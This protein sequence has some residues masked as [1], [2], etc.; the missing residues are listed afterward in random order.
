MSTAAPSS[1][2][3]TT[4]ATG[5][6]RLSARERARQYGVTPRAL[7]LGTALTVVCD[8]WIHYAEL[9]MGGERGHT[10][11]AGTSTPVGPICLLFVVAA[12][13]LLAGRLLPGLA[14]ASAEILVVYAMIT[15]SAVLS[16]SGQLHFIIPTVV[17]AWHYAND[18]N[19]WASMFHRFVPDVPALA[20]KDSEALDG[21]YKGQASVNWPLWIPQMAT[22]IAFMLA[23]AFATL[24]LVSILRRQW[25]DRERLSFPTVQ[26]PA[27]LMEEQTPLFRK[28]LFWIGA[29]IPFA[30]SVMNTLALNDP[31][32][33]LVS[34]R[35]DT[36]LASFMTAAPWNAMGRTPLSFYPFV[37][38]IAY[39]IPLDVT[40]SSWFFFLVT[41]AENV[42]GAALNIDAGMSGSPRAT[43]PFL[44]QQ[45]AG[46]FIAL[47]VISLWMSRSY[48]KEVFA[49][50]FGEPSELD[51][52]DEPL[53]YRGALIG[54]ACSAL[55]LIGF[56]V[57]S[58]MQPFIATLLVVL[59]F[60]YMI[61]A[62]RIR[63][64]AGNAW[65]FG[66]DVDVN[67]L[68]T[69]TL[70]TG[71]LTPQDLTVLAYMRPALAN[72][73]MRCMAM[74][75]QFDAMKMAD[76]VGA[77]RRR[78]FGAICIGTILGLTASFMIALMIWHHFG[79]EGKTDSWRVSQGR[80]PFDNVVSLMRNP[81][82][83]DLRGMGAIGFGFLV[84]AALMA[85]RSYFVWWPLHPVGYA[86][87][88]TNSMTS[89]W[90]PFLIAWLA[91]LLILRYGGARLYR[92][93]IPFA[94]GLIAGDLL[95][96]GLTTA[97]GAFTGINVYP[98]NW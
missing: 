46:A 17:A 34:L 97:I 72:F 13:N 3:T 27:A 77:S 87:A 19:A 30:F 5:T 76:M 15:T 43:F 8:L 56:C 65:L 60:T 82:Q 62:T 16:S 10:A 84:T 80:V 35:A 12:I 52:R 61:A 66:P 48:L 1:A 25:I 11:I 9:V 67:H 53:S 50:A 2:P 88:N 28:P 75:H 71:L 92:Q 20:Q 54:L 31:R 98:I 18:S 33:R 4:P 74:P 24:C 37:I 14:L 41:R 42:L 95:G 6:E 32:F 91:K 7:L 51:D 26:L 93:S 57:V 81:L 55:F 45:G 78:L 29:A 85:L 44:G 68:M 96:G 83:P 79:A 40:F 59:A 70:G 90:L 47:T 36:D 21:F 39:L 63:A 38:G 69:R 94:L 73:D 23:V 89:T 86:I 22:W 58:G 64:E 49:R